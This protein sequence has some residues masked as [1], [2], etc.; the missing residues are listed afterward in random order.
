ML[1]NLMPSQDNSSPLLPVINTLCDGITSF[2]FEGNSPSV[3]GDDHMTI[4]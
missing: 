1:C 2:P 3:S 4:M